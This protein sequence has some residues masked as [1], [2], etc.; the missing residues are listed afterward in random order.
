[1]TEGV[2]TLPRGFVGSGPDRSTEGQDFVDEFRVGEDHPTAAVP[3]QPQLVEDLAGLLSTARP[4][5]ERRERT[6]DNLA[7]RETSDRDD[8]GLTGTTSAASSAPR[9]P[10]VSS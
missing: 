6:P 3:F 2:K 9:D 7:A 5:D 10:A 1:M 4:L 8:H